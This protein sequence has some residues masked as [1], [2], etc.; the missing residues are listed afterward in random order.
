[1]SYLFNF[2]SGQRTLD[3]LIHATG[4]KF[5]GSLGERIHAGV[6]GTAVVAKAPPD[7]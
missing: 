1:M 4:G 2:L 3:A 5:G 6:D 7:G